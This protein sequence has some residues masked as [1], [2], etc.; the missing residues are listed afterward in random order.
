MVVTTFQ[1]GV[2][3]PPLHPLTSLPQLGH[4]ATLIGWDALTVEGTPVDVVHPGETVRIRLHWRAEGNSDKP[5][6]G[7]VHLIAS[8]GKRIAQDDQQPVEGRMPTPLWRPGLHIV[9]EYELVLPDT[10]TDGVYT[11][12]IGLYNE[13]T[14]Q[15]LPVFIKGELV[16]DSVQLGILEVKSP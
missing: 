16:G 8:D 2:Q 11:L 13:K 12:I 14:M 1:V 7:F 3:P 10:I 9:D 5:Y 15:R 4:L 6:K